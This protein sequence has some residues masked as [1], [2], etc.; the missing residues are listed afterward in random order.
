MRLTIIRNKPLHEEVKYDW[1]QIAMKT[2]NNKCKLPGPD[3]LAETL[4]KYDNA[5]RETMQHILRIRVFPR[6]KPARPCF[7]Q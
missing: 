3:K 5:R 2:G 6:E 4:R 7:H 1:V